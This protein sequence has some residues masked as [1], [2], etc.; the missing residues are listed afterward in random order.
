[1]FSLRLSLRLSL[2]DEQ[3]DD[4]E[5]DDEQQDEKDDE[6]DVFLFL[7]TLLNPFIINS[8][9]IVIILGV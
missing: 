8:L 1:V 2:S 7:F 9:P 3:Q 5:E 4:E 6:D